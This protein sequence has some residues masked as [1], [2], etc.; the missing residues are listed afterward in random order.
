MGIFYSENYLVLT[1]YTEWIETS[2]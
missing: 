1:K 2:Y